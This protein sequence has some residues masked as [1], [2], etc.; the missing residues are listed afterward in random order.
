MQRKVSHD[1]SSD[2]EIDNVSLAL[3]VRKA[4]KMM[5]SSTRTVSSLM[6]R[7]RSSS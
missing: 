4:T 5:K 6:A 3:M 2:D 7:R 1:S